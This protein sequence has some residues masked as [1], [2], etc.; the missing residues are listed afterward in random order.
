MTIA[1]RFQIP[2]HTAADWSGGNPVLLDRE[3]AA[4]RDT[5]KFKFGNGIST[6]ADLPYQPFWSRWGRIEGQI[7]DQP[8]I[9]AA[10]ALRLLKSS[11]LS[12]LA[13][14]VAARANLGLKALALRD[15]INGNDWSGAD[16]AIAD[17]GTGASSASAARANLGLGTAATR[18]TGTEGAV[19]P[20]LNGANTY[21]ARQ[22]YAGAPI[23]LSGTAAFPGTATNAGMYRSDTL[24]AVFFGGGTSSDLFFCNKAGGRVMSVTTGTLNPEFAGSPYPTSNGAQSLGT[25]TNLWLTTWT[26]QV[27]LGTG[28]VLVTNGT[29]SPEGSVSAPIGSL[30]TRSDGGAGTTLYIKESGTGN[31]GWTAK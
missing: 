18:D 13:D 2:G 4:E 28:R 22:T 11:N 19:V 6:W 23:V 12:D 30:Y 21:S 17:G 25:T 9:A 8:D 10:L 14:I 27:R 26:V 5:G 7:A 31:T 20:L 24:G 16:L 29:G 3:L 15:T 1:V